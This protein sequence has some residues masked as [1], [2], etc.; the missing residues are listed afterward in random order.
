[1]VFNWIS[2]DGKLIL[3]AR[4]VRTFSYG[5]LS[6]ILAI[7]LKL[8]GFNEIAIGFILTATLVN[9]VIFN[10]ISSSYADKFGRKKMLIMY[11]ALMI[12]S[13]IIFF[14]TNN[15]IALIV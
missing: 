14:L 13:A 2:L 6:I 5:L 10:L 8:V 1:M 7:Y 15:Y 11:A 4:I 12:A 3:G 9:S